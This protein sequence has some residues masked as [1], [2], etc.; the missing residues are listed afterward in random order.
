MARAP[1]RDEVIERLRGVLDDETT[2]EDASAWAQEWI[3]EDNPDTRDRAVW[4]ALVRMVGLRLTDD[5]G[6]Y[7]DRA[8]KLQAWLDDLLSA[9]KPD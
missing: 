1:H 2:R 6:N 7:V 9:P 8:E 4:R 5:A 3:L